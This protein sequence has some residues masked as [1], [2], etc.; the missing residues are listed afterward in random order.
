MAD[1]KIIIPEAQSSAF[2]FKRQGKHFT[3]LFFLIIISYVFAAP[4][5]GDGLWLGLSDR[6]WYWLAVGLTV[7]HQALVWIVWRVQLGWGLLTRLF[8]KADLAI[9]GILF[10]PLLIA[11]PILLFGLAMSDQGSMQLHR[12]L[13]ITLGHL[14]LLP[15]IYTLYSVGH[16]VGLERALGG[17]H[18]RKKYRE[19]P[20]VSEGAF[21]WSGNAMYAFAFLGFWSI[22]FLRGSLAALSFAIFQHAYIWVH[23]YCTE[24]PDMA[25][26]YG[27][28]PD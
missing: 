6:T 23:Y 4:A 17:D 10:I 8:G 28:S 27:A 12:D 25:L 19:L 14:L 24:Q 22:A 1:Q 2:F 18:F 13:E 9:W 16:Y 5:L 11:R 7:L 26:I 15:T 3:F 20:M 21:R